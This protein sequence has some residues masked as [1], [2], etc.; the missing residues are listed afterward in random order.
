MTK[1]F[2]METKTNTLESAILDV[3]KNA[4]ENNMSGE[5]SYEVG[6]DRYLHHTQDM[7]PGQQVEESFEN[8]T[9]EEINEN[10]D[11]LFEQIE[12]MSDEEF[13][14]LLE[15]SDELELEGILGA[16]GR[17]IK[18]VATAGSAKSRL[19]RAKKKGAKVQMKT[20]LVKQKAANSTA[21]AGLKALK[22]KNPGVIRKAAAKVGG[23][24]KSKIKKS[25]EEV[26]AETNKNDK[27]DDG[28]GLDAVQ[29]KAVKKKFDDRKDKDI[30]NDG[31]TDDSDEFM[32]KKRKAI[33]K[34][35]DKKENVK[36]SV[37]NLRDTI[38]NMWT[39][40]SSVVNPKEREELDMAPEKT[41]KK[42]KRAAEPSPMVAT[43]EVDLDEKPADFIRL[44]FSS[45]ADVKKAKKWMDQNLPG[46]NQ[47]FTGMDASGKDIEFEGVDDAEDLM[48]KLK[49]AGFKFK[50]DYR[51]EVVSEGEL[52]PALKKAI[53]AKK[54]KGSDKEDK[55]EKD[56]GNKFGKAL[57]AAKEKGEKT[58]V[59]AG[60]KYDVQ[61]ELSLEHAQ[62]FKVSSMKRALAKVWGME[63][64]AEPKKE[65][66][67]SKKEGKKTETG[68]KMAEVEIDPELKAK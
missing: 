5:Q 61:E 44:S 32:H 25:S 65:S 8:I 10:S 33:S 40:A 39:E 6:T 47:G 29:P 11:W 35:I 26:V 7:T 55:D 56:E 24:I 23:A 49:K 43:E 57:M 41:A 62:E 54:E 48:A 30:D 28:E 31:D 4:A 17:G 34:A 27:S 36:E 68:G 58:F 67:K 14:D 21:K 20:D 16:I 15:E 18:K 19:A 51:E 46:A 9:E 13:D 50:M 63:E 12:F 2:Y 42:M 37:S 3:W 53:D 22:K 52:P 64:S 38:I 66:A 59:V 60:K 1:K 45:P